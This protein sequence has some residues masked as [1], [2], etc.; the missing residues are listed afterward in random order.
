MPLYLLQ[1]YAVK[2]KNRARIFLP[3]YP[4][5]D[6]Y[7]KFDVAAWMQGSIP[8]SQVKDVRFSLQ[9]GR[10]APLLLHMQ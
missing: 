8:T 5:T 7:L 10:T 3:R 6:H 4:K 9:Q 1:K 2:K